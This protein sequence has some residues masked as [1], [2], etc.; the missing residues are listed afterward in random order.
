M[1]KPTA[2]NQVPA[3]FGYATILPDMD[4][5]TYSEAGYI[6]NK[7]K[8]KWQSITTS[9]PHGIEAVGAAAYSEHPSTEVLS[10]AFDLK[11]GSGP[12]LWVPGLEPPQELFNHIKNGG[13]LEAWNSIFEFFIWKN[14]CVKKMGWLPLPVEQLRDA[15][16]KS[17]AFSL[18]GALKDAAKITKADFL[19]IEDGNRLINKFSKPRNPTKKDPR[20]RIRP[21]EDLPDAQKLYD[22]NIGDIKAEAAVSLKTPDLSSEESQL[23]IIDQRINTRGVSIDIGSL[24]S[25]VAIVEQATAKYTAELSEITGGYV[26]SVGE[27]QKITE[28]LNLC[29]VNTPSIDAKH[30]KDLLKSD[31]FA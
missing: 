1:N 13:I 19:K 10:L 26:Q 16:A 2:Y 22:Y 12:R 8:N 9:P 14:V 5:E 6:F 3:G 18:P 15:M 4:L 7:E 29:G 31:E 27:I 11:D 17:Y 28:F 20:T 25:C 23:W 21:L 30:I 24:N